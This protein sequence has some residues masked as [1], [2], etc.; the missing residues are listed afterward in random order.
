MQYTA[1]IHSVSNGLCGFFQSGKET[2][3]KFLASVAVRV[4]S[5]GEE[6]ARFYTPKQQPKEQ[7]YECIARLRRIMHFNRSHVVHLVILCTP[8]HV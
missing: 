2:E 3:M 7:A 1:Q 4:N 5:A 8:L 6:R